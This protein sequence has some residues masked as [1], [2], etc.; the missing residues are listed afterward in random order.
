MLEL[1]ERIG[2]VNTGLKEDEM[3]RNIRKTRIQFWDDTSKLQVD[4]ECSICQVSLHNRIKLL[5]CFLFLER[6]RESEIE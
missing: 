6:E 4:K 1:G 3:G 5:H 2:H